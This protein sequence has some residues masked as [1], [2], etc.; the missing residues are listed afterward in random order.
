MG[1]PVA[2]LRIERQI[3]PGYDIADE[4]LPFVHLSRLDGVAVRIDDTR[5]S[6]IRTLNH[7]TPIFDSAQHGILLVLICAGG[8][9]PPAIVRDYRDE[10]SS[11]QNELPDKIGIDRFVADHIRKAVLDEGRIL[12]MKNC[13]V[14]SNPP[15]SQ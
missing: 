4:N 5:D 10:F 13:C 14:F 2:V 12:K 1:K 9:P 7:P 15:P 8:I 11:L 6:P 3:G